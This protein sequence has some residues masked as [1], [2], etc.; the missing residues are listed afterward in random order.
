MAKKEALVND[1]KDE[2]VPPAIQWTNDQVSDWIEELGF[3][4]YKP[5]FTTNMIDG[6]KLVAIEA[7]AFPNIGIT[8]FEHI[9]IIAKSIR[10]LLLLEEPDWTRS[11]SIPPRSDLGMYLEKK[12]K[13]GKIINMMTYQQFLLEHKNA[14]WQPPLSNHCLLLP[15]DPPPAEITQS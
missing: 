2:R 13:R 10:D 14:K 11:I 12:S 8:D 7:S 9:K 5:C 6:R 3:P 1:L 15:H 4:Q